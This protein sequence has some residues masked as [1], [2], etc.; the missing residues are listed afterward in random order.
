[1]SDLYYTIEDGTEWT[2]GVRASAVDAFVDAFTDAL[3]ARGEVLD[4]G[5]RGRGGTAE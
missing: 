2:V 5:E 4:V 1:M 3:S